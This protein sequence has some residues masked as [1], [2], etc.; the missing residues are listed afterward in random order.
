MHYEMQPSPLNYMSEK[1][2]TDQFLGYSRQG[3]QRF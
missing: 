3:L 2:L 1:I